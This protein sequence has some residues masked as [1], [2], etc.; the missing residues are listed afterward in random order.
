MTTLAHQES[1]VEI[2]TRVTIECGSFE[3]FCYTSRDTE[4]V[5]LMPLERVIPLSTGA[6]VKQCVIHATTYRVTEVDHAL[7]YATFWA[8]E[9]T[10][11]GYLGRLVFPYQ[12]QRAD[13][14]LAQCTRQLTAD[15]LAC[16]RAEL[17][18]D[19][20]APTVFSPARYWLADTQVW[21]V[22]SS[23]EGSGISL[24]AFRW[25]TPKPFPG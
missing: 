1:P 9:A 20:H 3:L 21:G 17:E 4:Q 22:R 5:F 13:V 12:H 23:L 19:G 8:A 2:A 15:L 16:L 18:S 25:S 6:W 11:A 7:S 24:Q 10:G 14:N